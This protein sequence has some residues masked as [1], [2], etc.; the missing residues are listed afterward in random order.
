M[1]LLR[2]K[3]LGQK[4]PIGVS[5][6]LYGHVAK[7]QP[8]LALQELLTCVV[9]LLLMMWVQLVLTFRII[10]PE[11]LSALPSSQ[12]LQSGSTKTTACWMSLCLAT[13]VLGMSS[14]ALKWSL[15]QE[16]CSC[17]CRCE[18]AVALLAICRRGQR[19]L[20]DIP[21]YGCGAP[22]AQER[23]EVSVYSVSCQELCTAD[24]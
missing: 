15:A 8:Q 23:D 22:S 16:P 17:V 3:H 14:R 4:W 18:F 24:S 11:K 1:F 13:T 19:G 5:M 12:G 6:C 21:E 10:L 7:N 9:V 2:L 20:L